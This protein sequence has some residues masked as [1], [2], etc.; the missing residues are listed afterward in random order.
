MSGA[1]VAVGLF[2]GLVGAAEMIGRYRDSTVRTFTVPATWIYV[3]MNAAGSIG[4]LYLL[5]S[6]GWDLGQTDAT[7]RDLTQVLVAG[8]GALAFFRSSL[9]K[10]KVGDQDIDVGPSLMLDSL[11]AAADRSVDRHQAKRRNRDVAAAMKNVDFEKA[12]LALPAIC[13]AASASVSKDDAAAL[14]TGINTI[15]GDHMSPHAKSLALGL[16]VV[17]LLGVDILQSSITALGD[18]ITS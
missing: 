15:S 11:L 9:F 7:K 1:Y 4:A 2:G 3:L 8:F 17:G 10:V 6:F 14:R 12:A 18:D 16:A 13:L 5:R